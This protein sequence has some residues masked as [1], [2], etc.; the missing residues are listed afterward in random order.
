MAT[1]PNRIFRFDHT[2]L[3]EGAI[4]YENDYGLHKFVVVRPA[5]LQTS[6]E[7]G[8]RLVWSAKIADNPDAEEISFM[9]TAGFEHYG[10]KIYTEDEVFELHGRLYVNG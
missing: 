5:E 1:K 4:F 9:I 8:T 3:V 10:P 2:K 6:A 7:N